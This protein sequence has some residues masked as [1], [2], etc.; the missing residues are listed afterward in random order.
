MVS[1][2]Y[3]YILVLITILFFVS[4]SVV[5][6]VG[7]GTNVPDASSMLDITSSDK[8]FLPPRMDTS[9]RDLIGAPATGLLIY[10]ITTNKLNYY[11]GTSWQVVETGAGSYV[12]LTSN[13]TIAG[14]K[15]FTGTLTAAGRLMLP[16]GEISYFN[17]SSDPN[18]LG[19]TVDIT[20]K[21]TGYANG[22]DNMMKINPPG[23]VFVNDMF[24][25]GVNNK[26]TYTGTVGRYFHIAL[27]FSYS[28]DNLKD[29][30]IFGVAKNDFSAGTTVVEDSSKVLITT[31]SKADYNSTAMHV[32]LWL[33]TND[34]IEFYV[35][36][37]TNDNRDLYIKS[38]NFV[39]I[40]M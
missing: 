34:S 2:K 17:N 30:F 11:N 4:V 13:Q 40:G 24:G 8:G 33:D 37:V 36:N 9:A 21:S 22:T 14:N 31:G 6:Q 12:D 20:A 23:S 16:M 15:T 32:L 5:A 38:F 19:F 29:V 10:N 3:K 18:V 7:I 39:A 26:L 25:T 27:S 35:G 28:P 1:L